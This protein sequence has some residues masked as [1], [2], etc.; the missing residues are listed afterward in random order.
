MG[1]NREKVKPIFV[2]PGSGEIN[3]ARI[4]FSPGPGSRARS[5][6]N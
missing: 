4:S 5:F 3:P 6:Q 1:Q 2:I